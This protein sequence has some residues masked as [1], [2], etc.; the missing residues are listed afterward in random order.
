MK[1]QSLQGKTTNMDPP[2]EAIQL[3]EVRDGL[4]MSTRTRPKVAGF[5]RVRHWQIQTGRVT[6]IASKGI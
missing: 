3:Q 1:L 4:F 6:L 2:F 5:P